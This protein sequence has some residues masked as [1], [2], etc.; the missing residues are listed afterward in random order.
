M[1]YKP[2]KYLFFDMDGVLVLSENQHFKAWKKILENHNLPTNWMNFNEWIG[3]SD[4]TNA[5]TIISKFEL[6]TS[7][8][9]L[10]HLKKQAFIELIENGFEKHQGR[11][12]FLKNA[13]SHFKLGLVS[14]ASKIEIEKIVSIE[15]IA[16]HFEFFIGNEDVTQ[17]KPHPMP[18]LHALEKANIQAHEALIIE[19]SYVGIS[20]ALAASIPV[21]GLETIASIPNNIKSQ[22][23]FYKDF[24]EIEN[25]LLA[26]AE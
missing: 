17:H 25:W 7:I 2:Y 20:A 26:Q 12:N 13:S 3:V 9:A 8:Q 23:E 6:N 24:N 4:T 10:H 5:Q 19:D 15:N 21:I 11:D 14:S 1:G 18:Y 22:V 16:H